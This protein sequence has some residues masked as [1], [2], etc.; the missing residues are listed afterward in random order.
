MNQVYI[1]KS[2]PKSKPQKQKLKLVPKAK[3]ETVHKVFSE[4]EKKRQ[5]EIKK[6]VK[7][8]KDISSLITTG[9]YNFNR[10]Y[11]P[12]SLQYKLI[13]LSSNRTKLLK[14]VKGENRKILLNTA[15]LLRRKG[16]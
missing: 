4:K 3:P 1:P 10:T 8:A 14:D 9:K 12:N 15:S 16:V 2:K 6:Y 13:N 5:M 11:N 7:Q